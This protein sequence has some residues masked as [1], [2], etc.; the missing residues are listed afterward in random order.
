MP[1]TI[2]GQVDDINDGDSILNGRLQVLIDIAMLSL[3]ADTEMTRPAVL[4]STFRLWVER[5]YVVT[6]STR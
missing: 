4:G 6:G 3:R 2:A 1:L 5:E